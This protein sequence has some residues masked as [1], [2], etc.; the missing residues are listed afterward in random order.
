MEDRLGKLRPVLDHGT[1]QRSPGFAI[2]G[3]RFHGRI[4][5]AL[6][7]DRG[8]VV[9]GMGKW[10]G[11]VDPCQPVVTERQRAE[12]GRRGGHGMHGGTEVMMK[13]GQRELHGPRASAGLLLGLED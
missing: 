9:E 1:D 3:E 8:A 2:F 11:G 12:E 7:Q 4:E 5:I 13:A 10:R 6:Q